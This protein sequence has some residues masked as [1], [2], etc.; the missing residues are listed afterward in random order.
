MPLSKTHIVHFFEDATEYC[1]FL[2][3][4]TQ[5]RVKH[6]F[7]CR[8]TFPAIYMVKGIGYC[9]KYSGIYGNGWRV[10]IFRPRK[11]KVGNGYNNIVKYY[12]AERSDS[13]V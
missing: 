3:L 13:N 4:I 2:R 10:V 1:Q 9:E 11:S 8:A 12:I 7:V 5:G 6:K